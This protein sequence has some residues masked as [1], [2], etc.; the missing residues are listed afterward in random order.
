MNYLELWKETYSSGLKFDKTLAKNLKGCKER[1]S[2]KKA[3]CFCID[4][5]M[6]E[7]KTTLAVLCAQ[8]YESLFGEKFEIE[9]QIGMGGKEFIK[10]LEYC[11][12]NNKH[13]VIYDEAGDFNTRA[14]L[15]YF[16]QQ[17][18]R[19]FETF[20]AME[21]LVIICLP[22]FADIDT[23][24]MKK[25]VLRFL[26]HCFGRTTKQGNYSV[27]DLSRMWY[28]KAK[29]PKVTVPTDAFKITNPNFYG[30]FKDLDPEDATA[31]NDVSMKGKKEIIRQSM[32]QQRGLVNSDDVVKATGYSL[33]SV[34]E[35]VGRI[36][37]KFEK[38][39]RT[40]YFDKS[41]IKQFL[42]EKGVHFDPD[43]AKRSR[44]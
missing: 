10:A 28:V 30:H 41:I 44:T 2:M 40:K 11:V 9:N 19:I 32:I 15:T 4:G 33:A 42:A 14:S 35:F 16:N 1:V 12:N 26:V 5:I 18:N 43:G 21:I 31:L 34:R 27:Y 3:S 22:S 36:K 6:G 8:Y 39:G 38:I 29:F 37:P 20:R 23:S 13:V 25:G 17:L 7:G 24:L